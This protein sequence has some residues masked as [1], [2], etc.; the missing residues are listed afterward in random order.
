M[1]YDKISCYFPENFTGNLANSKVIHRK[2]KME[3]TA[4]RND[5]D[6]VCDSGMG[7][8]LYAFFGQSGSS[9]P[10]KWLSSFCH[11]VICLSLLASGEVSRVAIGFKAV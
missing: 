9:S 5:T 1:F 11:S 2:P 10:N 4:K 3:N 6:T 7:K 8:V